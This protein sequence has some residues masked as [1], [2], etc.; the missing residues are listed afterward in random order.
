[1]IIII[2]VYNSMK[3]EATRKIT[4]WSISR[5]LFLCFLGQRWRLFILGLGCPNPHATY[6]NICLQIGLWHFCRNVF[7][8]GLAPDGVYPARFVTIAAVG[9]YPTFSPLP[10][11]LGGLFSVA[12]SLRLPLADVIRRHICLEPGLSS[13]SAFRR[14]KKQ[15]PDHL[16]FAMC[17]FIARNSRRT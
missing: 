7:L 3:I 5:V 11:K 14:L 17:A 9:F 2:I 12:L 13:Y 6:P 1:M 10:N 4:R 8:F 16:V 15:S